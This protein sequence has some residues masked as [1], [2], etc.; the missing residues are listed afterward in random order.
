MKDNVEDAD[1]DM[2]KKGNLCVAEDAGRGHCAL[3]EETD[4]PGVDAEEAPSLSSSVSTIDEIVSVLS[5]DR[6]LIRFPREAEDEEFVSAP[7]D[8][9]VPSE[10]EPGALRRI[11]G[12]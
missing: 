3:S 2:T 7:K 8:A 9:R 11:L 6:L 12:G 1:K 10:G 4:V 5:K